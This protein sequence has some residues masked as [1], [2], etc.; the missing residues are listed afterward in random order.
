MEER[1]GFLA[2]LTSAEREDL[3]ARGRVQRY[4]RGD[5][6]MREGEPSGHV[7]LVRRGRVKVVKLTEDGHEVVITIKGPGELLGEI[8]ALDGDPRTADVVAVETVDASLIAT[9]DLDQ[10]LAD[11]HR[12]AHVM[13]R[14]IVGRLRD[15]DRRRVEFGQ[16]VSNRVAR[17]IVE[18]YIDQQGGDDPSRL[19][20]THDELAGMVG[21]SRET[22]SRALSRLRARGLIATERRSIRVLDVDGLRQR[23]EVP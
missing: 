11:H 8:S 9:S 4:E 20:L 16:D 7:A 3:L 14:M 17:Q 6:L 15:A 18:L 13:L 19:P 22:V 1:G 5:F 2:S 23:A 12:V 10:F 21:A